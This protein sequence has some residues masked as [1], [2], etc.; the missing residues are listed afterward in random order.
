MSKYWAIDSPLM[1]GLGKIGDIV[2]LNIVFVIC[3]IPVVTIGTAITSLYA[4][5][6]KMARGDEPSVVKAFFEAFRRNFKMGTICWIIMAAVGILFCLDFH[7][8]GTFDVAVKSIA[9][10]LLGAGLV[11]YLMIFTWLFPYIARFENSLKAYFK[12]AFMLSVIH[13][14]FT[15]LLAGMSVGILVIVFFTSRT[16]VIATIV[17]FFIG[18]SAFAYVQSVILQKVFARYE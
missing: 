14:P 13:F 17:G 3:C 1:N 6:M 12:N 9:R 15:V 18:F 10:I 16:F 4:V 5:T 11:I 8:I 2:V 7:V